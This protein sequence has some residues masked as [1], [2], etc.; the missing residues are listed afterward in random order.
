MRTLLT[1]LVVV[2]AAVL[3]SV[4]RILPAYIDNDMNVVRPHAPYQISDRAAQLHA[5]LR[6]ADLHSDMLLWMRDPRRWNNRG[7]TD[8]PRL[9]HSN[10]RLQVFASVTK[11][12]SGQNYQSNTADSDNI[13]ALAMVQR[14][15]VDTW[16][17]LFARARYHARRLQRLERSGDRLVIGR[18]ASDLEQALAERLEALKSR[19]VTLP[20]LLLG[21]LVPGQSLKFT[22]SRFRQVLG[23]VLV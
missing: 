4:F 7:H 20:C 10:V 9:D 19:Q 21:S 6:V 14:W 1:I 5:E 18:S 8:L 22:R 15:P 11:T 12:P 16:G 3:I 2:M 13:T 17:S 23:G